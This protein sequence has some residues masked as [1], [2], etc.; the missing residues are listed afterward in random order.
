M[1]SVWTI[2]GRRS[3][4]TTS[5]R[6][7]KWAHSDE[8]PKSYRV[9]IEKIKGSDWSLASSRYKRVATNTVAHDTPTE[10][11]G[12]VLKLEQEIIKRGDTLL[13]RFGKNQ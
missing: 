12:D 11:L 3:K 9:P 2:S 7:T 8:G 6:I 4:R 5:R 1:V 13:A 10:I